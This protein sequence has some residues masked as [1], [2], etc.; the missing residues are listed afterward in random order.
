[1]RWNCRIVSAYFIIEKY[2][3]QIMDRVI[4][5]YAG[6]PGLAGVGLLENKCEEVLAEWG[7][8]FPPFLF[9]VREA[10]LNALEANGMN[11]A[12]D[13]LLE[14]TITSN[15]AWL[16]AEVPDYGPGLPVDWKDKRLCFDMADLLESD[17]GRGLLFMSELCDHI[18][19]GRDAQGRHVMI[20]KVRTG[21]NG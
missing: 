8:S 1:M 18:D 11:Q 9:A 2:R 16:G 20:L 10:L 15:G 19:S 21:N 3:G 13:Q 6:E 12:D 14:V 5:L 7:V 4:T 17:R